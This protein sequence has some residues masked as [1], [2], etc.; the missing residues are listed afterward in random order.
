MVVDDGLHNAFTDLTVWQGNLWL[1]YVSS[2]SHFANS[3]S[4]IVLL[5]S[6]DGQNWQEVTQIGRAHV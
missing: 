2:P 5:H 3:K 4:R 1:V 6:S